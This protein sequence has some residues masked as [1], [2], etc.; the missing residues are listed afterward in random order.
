MQ[1]KKQ[2]EDLGDVKLPMQITKTDIVVK[3][4]SG[5]VFE[6]NEDFIK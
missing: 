4:K 6:N 5:Y 1:L 2:V 3:G